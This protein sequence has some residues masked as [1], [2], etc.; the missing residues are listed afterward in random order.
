[1][2]TL[3][4][5]APFPPPLLRMAYVFFALICLL[6]GSNF[7]LMDRAKEVF[8]PAEI[9]LARLWGGAAVLVIVVLWTRRSLR[10]D[11]KTL[12]KIAIVGLVANAYP[13]A[14][15]PWLL[16]RGTDHSFLAMFVPLTPLL[17]IVASV[18]MLG[19]RPTWQQMLGVLGGLA[20]LIWM[21]GDAE[22]HHLQLRLLPLVLSVPLAYAISNTF[23]R[24]HLQHVSSLVL[25]TLILVTAGLFLLPLAIGE[26]VH[27]PPQGTR[28]EWTAAIASLLVLGPLGTGACIGMFV[29]L[30][31]EKGPLFAGMVTYIVPIVALV[32]GYRDGEYISTTQLIAMIGILA[33]VALVQSS[34]CRLQLSS[35]EPR[36]TYQQDPSP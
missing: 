10:I 6:F 21:S 14:M 13:F 15:Q 16:E 8:S 22:K 35:K 7:M 26:Y 11:A 18:P 17:T 33:M 27:Q 4:S 2:Q 29:H 20:L 30:V 31:Q 23:L 36:D 19:I 5:L 1:M 28:D 24:R 9:G 34:P 3:R 25:S 32:W 12:G